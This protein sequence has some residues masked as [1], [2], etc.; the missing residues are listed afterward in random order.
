MLSREALPKEAGISRECVRQ[1]EVGLHDPSVGVSPA[2]G[3]G[4]RRAVNGSAGMIAGGLHGRW[5]FYSDRSGCPSH[6]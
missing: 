4:A 2:P 1:L 5:P 3:D 6:T